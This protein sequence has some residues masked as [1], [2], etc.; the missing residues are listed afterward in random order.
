M[1]CWFGI[2]WLTINFL[3]HWQDYGSNNL[4]VQDN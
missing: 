2:G 4:Q 1:R 3:D